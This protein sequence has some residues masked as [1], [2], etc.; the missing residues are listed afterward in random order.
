[1]AT[2]YLGTCN[3]GKGWL[4]YDSRVVRRDAN[5]HQ[6]V[7]QQHIITHEEVSDE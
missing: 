3:C 7:F 6:S 4:D 1:M 2:I 5:K